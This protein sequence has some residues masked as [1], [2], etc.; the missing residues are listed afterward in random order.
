MH[1]ARLP[2]DE[3]LASLRARRE[4][5]STAEAARR[6]IE[7][8]PNRL[9]EAARTPIALRLA[10]Q[11][12]HFFAVIL[13]VAA[14]LACVAETL[15]PGQGMA[16]LAVAI[17][18]VILIN[19]AFAFWQEVRAERTVH[20]LRALLPRE[21][22]TTRHG[23]RDGSRTPGGSEDRSK[24]RIVACVH[25]RASNRV[26]AGRSVA[27]A[28]CGRCDRKLVGGTAASGRPV[29]RCP[30]CEAN[31]R[32]RSD[33]GGDAPGTLI[34]CGRCGEPLRGPAPAR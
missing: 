19:G 6:A 20:A 33:A 21:T 32:L 11:F 22:R 3:A 8:G 14:A 34:R 24:E 9:E 12:T 27:A 2:V 18:G 28:R 7:Y 30:K 5:L 17:I 15:E 23:R 1:P 29:V 26:P 13:W 10:R 25:C 16:M 4:G 31:N